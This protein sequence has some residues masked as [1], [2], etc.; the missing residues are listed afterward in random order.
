MTYAASRACYDADSH[1]LET[2]DWVTRFADPEVR[3]KLPPLAL[4]AAGNATHGFIA[5]AQ[6]RVKDEAKTALIDHDVIA[7]PKGW[8]AF[9]AFDIG[10]RRKALDDLRLPPPVGF[11]DL[12]RHAVPF[13]QRP[14]DPLRRHPGAQ[15]G[16]DRL[17][18][19]GRA[20]D[21]GRSGFPCRS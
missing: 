11:L 9:G 12:L 17:L 4:G 7:G 20:P 2:L 5:K 6:A 18:Q 14:R 13:G 15:P 3:E 10:E 19:R 16:H 8:A 21:R 1:I